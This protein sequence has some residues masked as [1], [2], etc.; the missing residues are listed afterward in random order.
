MTGIGR[1]APAPPPRRLPLTL[2]VRLLFGG[3]ARQFGWIFVA[4]G[5]LF[6]WVFDAGSTIIEWADFRG[7]VE[8]VAGVASQWESTSMSVNDARVY[9]T[10][11]TYQVGAEQY[12]GASYGSGHW[13]ETGTPV[14]VEYVP[15]DP[16]T[17]RLAGFRVSPAGATV[18]FIFVFPLVGLCLAIGGMV[19]PLRLRRLL[20]DGVVTEG[21]VI[22]T[23][24][25]SVVINN[26]PVMKVTFE[27]E[28]EGGG[29]FQSVARSH[30][31]GLLEDESR[32]LVVY[33]PR[34]PSSSAMLDE[35]PSQP[36]FDERGELY[37][38]AARIP[39]A[40]FLLL[41]GISVLTIFRYV[42][43]LL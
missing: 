40:L 25:T 9:R 5:M 27:F 12:S 11:Y 8:T 33:D 35:V 17:S 32:E 38:S 42:A 31:P 22:G 21:R 36:R 28:A 43:S 14:T 13:V 23:E 29:I 37:D 15:D 10:F 26:A 20:R 30:R 16:A 24:A 19:R 39:A 2:Q 34:D 3:F 7:D 6:V 41:P 4:F 18:L 1:P